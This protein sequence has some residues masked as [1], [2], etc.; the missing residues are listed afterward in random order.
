MAIAF[1]TSVLLYA[2]LEPTT[3][4]GETALDLIERSALANAI[5]PAQVLGEILAVVRRRRPAFFDLAMSTV[6]DF[7]SSFQIAPTDSD[8]VLRAGSLASR[9]R[10]QVWDAVICA[11]SLG[12]GATHLLSERIHDDVSLAGLTIINPFAVANRRLLE[13]L[14]PTQ[15]PDF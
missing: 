9:H 1:D 14:L 10:L 7:A 8:V 6:A 2:L 15:L 4:K 13:Q 5:I 11:A 3:A 12:V